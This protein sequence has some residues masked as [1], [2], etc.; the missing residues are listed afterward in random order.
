MHT[1]IAALYSTDLGETPWKALWEKS[2]EKLRIEEC[3]SDAHLFVDVTFNYSFNS[4][5]Q[6]P[7]KPCQYA[8]ANHTLSDVRDMWAWAL[9]ESE[10]ESDHGW[11]FFAVRIERL[12][13]ADGFQVVPWISLIINSIWCSISTIFI[14]LLCQ[15]FHLLRA[16]SHRDCTKS[17]LIN[18]NHR[19]S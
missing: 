19:S 10:S 7:V 13:K 9:S 5:S 2:A 17:D 14:I 12:S 16:H 1:L 8:K 4:P 3:H 11:P 6:H 15:P 18:S